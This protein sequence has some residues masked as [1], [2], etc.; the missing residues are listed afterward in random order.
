[1]EDSKFYD[2]PLTSEESEERIKRSNRS[3]KE[4]SNKGVM[5]GIVREETEEDDE[6]SKWEE[7]DVAMESTLGKGF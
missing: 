6:G 4:I 1:M 2:R 7:D 3:L 5:H